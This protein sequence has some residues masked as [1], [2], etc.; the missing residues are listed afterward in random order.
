MERD[1]PQLIL[2]TQILRIIN[3]TMLPKSPGPD[4]FSLLA[5]KSMSCRIQKSVRIT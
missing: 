3:H 2:V 4:R 5:P 1:D